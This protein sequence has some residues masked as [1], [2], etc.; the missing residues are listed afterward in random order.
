MVDDYVLS[1]IKGEERRKYAKIHGLSSLINY[2]HGLP[3]NDEESERVY[4]ICNDKG[5]TWEQYY[6]VPKKEVIY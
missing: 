4:K 1:L 3:W 6:K 2:F 5:I